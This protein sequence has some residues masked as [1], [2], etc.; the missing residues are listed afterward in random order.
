MIV[1]FMCQPKASTESKKNVLGQGNENGTLISVTDFLFDEQTLYDKEP[2]YCLFREQMK[3]WNDEQVMKYFIP[4]EEILRDY[5]K[6][7]NDNK[8]KEI[9]EAIR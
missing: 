5:Y 9:F 4:P 8:I 3:Q 2:R 6:K 7:K 1:V